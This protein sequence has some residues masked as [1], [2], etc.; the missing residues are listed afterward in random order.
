[1]A[2]AINTLAGLIVFNDANNDDI[3]VS[4]LLD[5]A[6]LMQVMFAKAASNG[7]Q[8]K[9]VKQ[10]VASASAFRAVNTGLAKTFSQDEQVTDTLKFLDGSFYV[11]V[12]IADGYS[13][14][15]EAYIQ[16]E[17]MRTLRQRMFG[18][19]S[20]VLLG[21]GNDAN[22]F[23]GLA[24]DPQLDKTGDTMCT[25]P[26]N[27]GAASSN[28]SVYLI[29]HGDPDCA[30]IMGNGGEI[31][32]GETIVQMVYQDPTSNSNSF[33]AYYTPVGAYAGFQIGGAYSAA[34]IA[35]INCATLSASDALTDDD[36]YGA[37]SL[38]PAGRQPNAIVMNRNALRLLRN[39]RTAV[40]ATGAPAPRPT[41]VEGIPIIV[42]DAIG[43]A[44]ST[45]AAS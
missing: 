32:V 3:Q 18:L 2:N 9:Y 11:D 23:A 45:V 26:A 35:N 20:Q 31:V 19:E 17:L 22:G 24:D 14:G 13:G 30:V 10:T 33:A 6:P 44:E 21:T 4:D 16:K 42:T 38:F 43:S 1:M 8:H 27:P 25:V 40:N 7:T 34:R 36:I 12:A 39:S 41:D 29:R 15:P 28:T 5:D 37:L